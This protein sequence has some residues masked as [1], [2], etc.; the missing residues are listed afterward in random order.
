MLVGTYDAQITRALEL[1]QEPLVAGDESIAFL[2]PL[3]GGWFSHLL[4]TLG[5]CLI[6]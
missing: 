3:G 4:G 6:I 5:W 2:H 1:L